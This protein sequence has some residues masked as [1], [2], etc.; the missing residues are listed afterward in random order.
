MTRAPIL[1]FTALLVAAGF[2]IVA[3]GAVD[4][5]SED[6]TEVTFEGVTPDWVSP[7]LLPPRVSF[8]AK[9]LA[10][11]EFSID[12]PDRVYVNVTTEDGEPVRHLVP[13]VNFEANTADQPT[14]TVFWNG[15]TDATD[16]YA[17]DG[18]Y[19]VHIGTPNT[20][21]EATGTLSVDRTP[22]TIRTAELRPN[23][24]GVEDLSIRVEVDE[25]LLV[26]RAQVTLPGAADPVNVTLER[27]DNGNVTGTNLTFQGVLPVGQG[28]D[29]KAPVNVTLVDRAG[30]PQTAHLAVTVDRSTSDDSQQASGTSGGSGGSGGGGGG[31][32]S[33]DTSDDEF[34]VSG[35]VLPASAGG[36]IHL[37]AAVS[38]S[39]ADEAT[40]TWTF[41]NGSEREGRTIVLEDLDE[42]ALVDVAVQDPS[43]SPADEDRLLL[44]PPYDGS[45]PALG[46]RCASGDC[47]LASP[48]VT[49]E[50]TP[51][52]DLPGYEPAWTWMVDGNVTSTER[53][54]TINLPGEGVH[55]VTLRVEVGPLTL[56][57][58]RRVKVV[59]PPTADIHRTEDD[60]NASALE[61]SPGPNVDR[62]QVLLGDQVLVNRTVD[63]TSPV[64]VDLPWDT[65]GAD[66]SA[67][68][69]VVLTRV[70]E[71][72]TVTSQHAVDLDASGLQRTSVDSSSDS[73]TDETDD[74]K[75]AAPQQGARTQDGFLGIPASG[76]ALGLL[77]L[78]ASAPIIDHRRR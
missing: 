6:T 4:A 53:E 27:P 74:G 21:S 32:G 42:P 70:E 73:S 38:G 31:G 69:V 44:A 19:V 9:D 36:K 12:R 59:P 14:H 68:A 78:I 30:V 18:T 25:P 5:Q 40:V 75:T 26:A 22:P 20:T 67:Q 61:V 76:P 62:L 65:I 35:R 56:E 11:I 48:Q 54:P 10:A 16:E 77:A 51:D 13:G 34:Q 8:G 28:P 47:L 1:A 15:L 66:G 33:S 45:A 60:G 29:G 41:P 2:L 3:A 39:D 63:G 7:D 24:V 55:E 23:P 58:T 52:R 72:G 17:A 49:M 43:G 64:S 46:I 57:E 37:E 71:E 50:P